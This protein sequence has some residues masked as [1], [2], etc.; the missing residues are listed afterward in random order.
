[1]FHMKHIKLNF[2]KF[3]LRQEEVPYI[4]H[5]LRVEGLWVDPDKVPRL[6]DVKG[7]QRRLVMVNYLSKLTTHTQR[8]H[9]GVDGC[10]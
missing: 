2:D 3:K 4:G 10:L 5:I 6:T 1:M 9:V 7:V 8:E